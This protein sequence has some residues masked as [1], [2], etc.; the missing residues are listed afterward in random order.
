M[1]AKEDYGTRTR[2][3][4]YEQQNNHPIE[5]QKL[6]QTQ[7]QFVTLQTLETER[8]LNFGYIF[9][10]IIAIFKIKIME[11]RFWDFGK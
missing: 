7:M 11:T 9:Y 8:N 2:K 3:E 10:I 6:K 1:T 4:D 5:A